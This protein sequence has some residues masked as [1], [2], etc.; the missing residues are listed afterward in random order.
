MEAAKNQISE[1]VVEKAAEA[2]AKIDEKD[3]QAIKE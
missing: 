1:K 3:K 2:V